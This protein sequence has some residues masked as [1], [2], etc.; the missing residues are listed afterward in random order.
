MPDFAEA[1]GLLESSCLSEFVGFDEFD[2][3]ALSVGRSSG[4]TVAEG[5]GLLDSCTSV[6][7]E[8]VKLAF[9]SSLSSFVQPVTTNNKHV[10]AATTNTIKSFFQIF[11]PPKICLCS[12]ILLKVFVFIPDSYTLIATEQINTI[13][14]KINLK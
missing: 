4:L 9:A 1:D 3:D 2:G 12:N 11:L 14:T 5:D 13:Q 6:V 8:G 7:G 10:I